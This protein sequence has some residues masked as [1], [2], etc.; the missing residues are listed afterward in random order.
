MSRFF[1]SV[2]I[3]S[4]RAAICIVVW[5]AGVWILLLFFGI[6]DPNSDAAWAI[7][8]WP[9]FPILARVLFWAL[10]GDELVWWGD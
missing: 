6:P 7:V 3:L 2:L 1:K 9:A 5:I 10:G 4:L 8:F